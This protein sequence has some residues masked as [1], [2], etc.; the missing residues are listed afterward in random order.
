MVEGVNANPAFSPYST[1]TRTEWSFVSGEA[2]QQIVPLLQLDY[3]ANL[4]AEGRAR[5]NA[6][7][8]V[9]PSVLG[10]PGTDVSSLG[11]EVSYDDGATWHRPRTTRHKGTWKTSLAAPEAASFVTLRAT[12]RDEKGGSITQTLTRAYGLK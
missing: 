10:D 11:L 9:T 6:A 2:E 3:E 1:S 12:A 7:L 4:D 5:R 8:E